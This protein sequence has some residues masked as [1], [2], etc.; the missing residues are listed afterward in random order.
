MQHAT[1][2]VE[3]NWWSEYRE[4]ERER[5][6]SPYQSVLQQFCFSEL[7][8]VGIRGIDDASLTHTCAQCRRW[9]VI[10]YNKSIIMV[11]SFT[12]GA[13][14]FTSFITHGFLYP[15]TQLA[16]PWNSNHVVSVWFWFLMRN[17]FCIK[18]GKIKFNLLNSN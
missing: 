15:R 8:W 7:T 11:L 16:F 4:R 13:R 6:T 1:G 9:R 17:N 2:T 5:K 18:D 12:E 10:W 14:F 3:I